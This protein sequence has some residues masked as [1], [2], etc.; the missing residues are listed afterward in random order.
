MIRLAKDFQALLDEYD[1]TE[2]ETKVRREVQ[3]AIAEF[4]FENREV[5]LD[6][7][8]TAEGHHD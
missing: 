2:P 4:G 7:L 6:A 5:I 3:A 1:A 8:Y